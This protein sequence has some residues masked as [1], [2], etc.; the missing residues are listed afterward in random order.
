[1][2]STSELTLNL[3]GVLVT[4]GQQRTALYKTETDTVNL[5]DNTVNLACYW[6]HQ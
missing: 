6:P 2:S 4:L 1:M 3:H 5:R